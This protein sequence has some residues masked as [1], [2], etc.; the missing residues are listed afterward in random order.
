MTI[1]TNTSDH[2]LEMIVASVN[3]ENAELPITL[4]VDGMLLTGKLI[5]GTKYFEYYQTLF[6]LTGKGPVEIGDTAYTQEIR[7]KAETE[8]FAAL[9]G[10]VHAKSTYLHLRDATFHYSLDDDLTS[11]RGVIWRGMI[12]K[13]SGFHFPLPNNSP[14]YINPKQ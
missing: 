7:V 6:P 11:R 14:K 10:D 5:S 12:E 8:R 13:V 1:T 9:K 3:S 4:L 2:F